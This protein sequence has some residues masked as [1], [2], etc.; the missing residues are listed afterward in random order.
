MTNSLNTVMESLKGLGWVPT[1]DKI[2]E[3]MEGDGV[4]VNSKGEIVKKEITMQDE[5]DEYLEMKRIMSEFESEV[6]KKAEKLKAYMKEQKITTLEGSKG[7]MVGFTAP[8]TSEIKTG[9]YSKY[10]LEDVEEILGKRRTKDVTD[11]VVNANKLEGL[12]K[13]GIINK[14][15]ADQ[16]EK[17][18]QTKTGAARFVVMNIKTSE[19]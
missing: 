14:D 18:K 3:L 19:K 15:K 5:V 10:K 4:T 8:T 7:K 9:L 16:I 13:A 17:V 6:K 12:I 1:E 11:T 2:K